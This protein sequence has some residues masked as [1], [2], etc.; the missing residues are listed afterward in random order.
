MSAPKVKSGRLARAA[1]LL[2]IALGVFSFLVNEAVAAILIALGVAMYLFEWWL[3]RKVGRA[4]ATT[5]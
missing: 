1:I 4:S 3:V 5:G 2:M